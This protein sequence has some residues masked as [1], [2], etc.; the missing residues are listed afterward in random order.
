MERVSFSFIHPLL[1]QCFILGME[2]DYLMCLC[3]L[4]VISVRGR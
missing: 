3:C 4:L 2:I 1:L